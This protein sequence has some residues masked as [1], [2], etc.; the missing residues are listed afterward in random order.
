M[1]FPYPLCV[2]TD[3]KLS[4]LRH[5]QV[6]ELALLGGTPMVQLRDKE[7]NLRTIYEEAVIIRHLCRQHSAVFIV[8]DRLDLALAVEANGVHLGQDDLPAARA[9]SLLK[10]GM[11]LGISTHSIG[12]ARA[13]EAAGADYI[14]F[15]PVFST[16]TKAGIRPVVGL[17]GIRQVKAAV[18][19]PVLAIGGITLDRVSEVI[20]AGADGVAVISAIVGSREIPATCRQFLT[21]IHHGR[22]QERR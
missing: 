12:E 2:I 17:E 9:R 10:H 5:H 7:G 4:G 14:G 11:L 1:V 15:G 22:R 3:E 8:N 6:A 16:G 18:Q 19:I 21:R 20:G 13:A